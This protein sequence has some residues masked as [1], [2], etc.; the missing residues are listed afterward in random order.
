MNFTGATVGGI[1]GTLVITMVM[2]L[3]PRIGLPKRDMVGMLGI[4]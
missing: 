2:A 1:I 4:M 3:A